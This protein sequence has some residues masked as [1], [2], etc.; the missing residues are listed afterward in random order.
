SKYFAKEGKRAAFRLTDSFVTLSLAATALITLLLMFAAEPVFRLF[1]TAS[2]DA[3]FIAETMSLGVPM[4]RIILPTIILSAGAYCVTGVLQ[5]MDEFNVPAAMSLASNILIIVYLLF[6]EGTFGLTGL[7]AVFLLGWGAQLAIQLPAMFKKGYRWRPRWDMKTSGLAEIGRLMLPVLISSWAIPVNQAVNEAAVARVTGGAAMNTAY[8]MYSVIMGVFVLSITNVLYTKFS[9]LSVSGG[10]EELSGAVSE[11]ARGMLFFLIPLS[12]GVFVLASP[13][14]QAV[15]QRGAFT[16]EDTALTAPALRFFALGMAGF[17]LHNVASRAYFAVGKTNLPLI[18]SL[19]AIAVNAALSF[20]LVGPMGTA[21]PAL[22]SSV[23]ITAAGLILFVSL[24]KSKITAVDKSFIPEL[25]K[26]IA[27][28]GTMAIIAA[29]C[30]DLLNGLPVILAAVIA[31]LIGII[32]YAAGSYLLKIKEARDIIALLRKKR[33]LPEDRRSRI[34]MVTNALVLGGAETHIL[35]LSR[36]LARR[37]FTVLVASAG[38]PMAE[39]LGKAGIKHYEAPLDNK[40][41]W[42]MLL[43][44]WKLKKIVKANNIGLVHAHARI[45]GFICGLLCRR[46]KLNLVTTVHG[47]FKTSFLYD[48]LTDWGEAALAVSGDIRDH[49]VNHYG[50]EPGRVMLTIN[51]IDTERFNPITDKTAMMDELYLDPG[52]RRIMSVSRLDK[53]ISAVA[54]E[55]IKAAPELDNMYDNSLDFI[56]VGDGDNFDAVKSAA[57][58]ANKAAGREMIILTGRRYDTD[59]LLAAADIFVNVSRSAMEAMAAGKPVIL[60]GGE[61]YSGILTPENLNDEAASNFTARG[62]NTPVSAELLIRDIAALLDM[63]ESR[64]NELR[65]AGRDYIT[66]HYSVERMASDAMELY[67]MARTPGKRYDAVLSGYY[68]SENSGDDEILQA[69]IEAMRGYLP[70]ARIAVLSRKPKET[71]RIHNVRSVNMFNPFAMWRLMGKTILLISGGGTLIQDNSSTR[72]LMYYLSVMRLARLRGC[73]VM[74]YASGV[75]PLKLRKNRERAAA[76]LRKTD[77]I[78]L[79]DG[80]SMETLKQLNVTGVPTYVTA[81]A[82]FGL[83]CGPKPQEAGDYFCVAVR[84]WKRLPSGFAQAIADFVGAMKE[85][86]GLRAV[87]LLMQPSRDLEISKSIMSLSKSGGSLPE[88]ASQHAVMEIIGKARFTVAMR[89]HTIIFSAKMGTPVIGLSYDPKVT[90]VMETLSQKYCVPVEAVKT[91]QLLDFAA[92]IMTGH[93]AIS[94]ELLDICAALEGKALETARLAAGIII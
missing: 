1:I 9:K 48:R 8:Q 21:G 51:G 13:I 53:S 87:F 71:S 75:G 91:P 2:G 46:M 3:A 30:F 19:A 34:L 41:P 84:G 23:S 63:D 88:P 37:G 64:L 33:E 70:G 50:L 66:H 38:G 58:E 10:G 72:S 56:I 39:E 78:T 54:L 52:H 4:L 82:V 55:L 42:N 28:S 6:F 81:D 61:G 12:A 43:S 73:K 92:E 79:R 57:L 94:K 5:A 80:M 35:E 17:G 68:G 47:M 11:S 62:G 76:A 20:L 26:I 59:R 22:A 77:L 25:I 93:D 16:A 67:G 40:M 14:I 44:Y 86:Y 83:K 15:F 49:L 74:V 27:L 36:E 24:I 65:T 60:A 31:A 85:R 45:P 29:I 90:G 7:A 32:W 89:L 69:I 18:A